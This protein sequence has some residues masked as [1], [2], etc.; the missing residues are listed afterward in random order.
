MKN[1]YLTTAVTT[2]FAVAARIRT[3]E[4]LWPARPNLPEGLRSMAA[5]S[6]RQFRRL[7]DNAVAAAL[8]R[9]EQQATLSALGRLS[10]AELK[11]FGLYR[12]RPGG[13]F[14][15]YRDGKPATK[16]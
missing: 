4:A 12:G 10:D 9:R 1:F 13:I 8:A 16:R 3:A 15:R 6:S 2:V 11:D 5:R 7:V 14:H